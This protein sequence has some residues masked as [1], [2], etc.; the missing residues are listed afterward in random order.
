MQKIISYS[1]QCGCQE[2][3][4]LKKFV[5]ELTF[6]FL[7][8]P[9]PPDHFPMLECECD[10]VGGALCSQK[11]SFP[12]LFPDA[13]MTVFLS[14]S[15]EGVAEPHTE[16]VLGGVNVI[17]EVLLLTLPLQTEAA[18]RLSSVLPLPVQAVLMV[19]LPLHVGNPTQRVGDSAFSCVCSSGVGNLSELTFFVVDLNMCRKGAHFA[20]I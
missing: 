10:L 17:A 9:A 20:S 16:L 13:V 11:N 2:F 3:W 19:S 1:L 15:R 6:R 18:R 4:G 7:F 12:L 14:G 8:A 5:M